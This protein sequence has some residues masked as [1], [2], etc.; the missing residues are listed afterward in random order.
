MFQ[1]ILNYRLTM[2]QTRRKSLLVQHITIQ[3]TRFATNAL[4]RFPK[5]RPPCNK[6]PPAWSFSP[7]SSRSQLCKPYRIPQN[8]KRPPYRIRILPINTSS[9]RLFLL[10]KRQ[11]PP[12]VQARNHKCRQRKKDKFCCRNWSSDGE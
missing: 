2:V 4:L 1:R 9:R 10:I 7:Y 11:I 5:A 6:L 3:Q 8:L 12:N